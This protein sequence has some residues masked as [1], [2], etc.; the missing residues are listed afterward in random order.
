MKQNLKNFLIA[1]ITGLIVFGVCAILI[2]NFGLKAILGSA[3]NAQKES[4]EY[5]QQL[6][7][8]PVEENAPVSQEAPL[9][10]A[11]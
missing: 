8:T 7:D 3:E 4:E 11:Q 6:L 10:D 5:A 9:Q 2:I 1:F